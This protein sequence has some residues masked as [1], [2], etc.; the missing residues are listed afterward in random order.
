[1]NQGTVYTILTTELKQVQ[2]QKKNRVKVQA[3]FNKLKKKRLENS[4]QSKLI[5]EIG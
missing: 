5:Q 3:M 2:Y 1:M 4:L